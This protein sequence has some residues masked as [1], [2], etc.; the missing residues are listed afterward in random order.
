[1]DAI[2]NTEANSQSEG[3]QRNNQQLAALW[4]LRQVSLHPDLLGGGEIR[5][6]NNEVSAKYELQRSGKLSWLLE[7]LDE[8]QLQNEKVLI[9]CVQKKLQEALS[10]SLGRIYGLTIPVI[11]GDT[12]ASSKTNPEE[13]RL[14]LINEFSQQP[15]FGICILSPIA[16][17]AGLNIAAANHVIHLERHWNPAKENQATDRVYR[18]GQTRTVKVYL[19]VLA[20]PS[21]A[22]FD[23]V[24]YRL[25]EKKTRITRG[26]RLSATPIQFLDLKSLM[27]FLEIIERIKNLT[28]LLICRAH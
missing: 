13:T 17:G 21:M 3:N 10:C 18:I 6:T 8:I 20:H 9:F 28:S 26:L 23:H 14:G 16:A 7:C 12:K 15:G 2:Q 1:M 25:L 11:N 4:Q 22:S 24:L 27:N 19:P 5:S